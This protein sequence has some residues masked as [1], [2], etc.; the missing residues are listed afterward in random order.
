VIELLK[1]IA[2][3]HQAVHCQLLGFGTVVHGQGLPMAWC[4]QNSMQ[5][6]SPLP[7]PQDRVYSFI[8]AQMV[9]Q[10]EG[11]ILKAINTLV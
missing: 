7:S 9:T 5:S 1:A 3:L 10:S 11:Q 6:C 2:V 8:C 4:C